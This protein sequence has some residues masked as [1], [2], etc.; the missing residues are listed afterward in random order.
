VWAPPDPDAAWDT[1]QPGTRRVTSWQNGALPPLAAGAVLLGVLAVPGVWAAFADLVTT[2]DEPAPLWWELVVSAV[3]ALAAAG[4]AAAVVRRRGDVPS[5]PALA[6][7][8]GLE[9]LA[10]NGIAH[11][12]RV[13]A[14]ALDRFDD[15][16]V[17]GGVRAGARLGLS[18]ARAVDGR[19]EWSVDGAVRA[20]VRG[21]RGLGRLARRPQT[22]QLHQY[23]AQAVVILA[24][25]AVLLVVLR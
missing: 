5:R 22:G 8:L 16:V 10:R 24:A 4:V 9:A 13:T 18:F 15:R 17:A 14:E 6:D 23:Y 1:E 20:V 12:T 25:L 21:F 11:P 7:W 2:V 19:V 3:V